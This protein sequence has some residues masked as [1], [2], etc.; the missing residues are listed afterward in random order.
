MKGDLYCS[1]GSIIQIRGGIDL[2]KLKRI[3]ITTF[4]CIAMLVASVSVCVASTV[5]EA[6]SVLKSQTTETLAPDNKVGYSAEELKSM[7]RFDQS[8]LEKQSRAYEAHEKLIHSFGPVGM[9]KASDYPEYYGGNYINDEG[10]LVVYVTGNIADYKQDFL[11]RS[12]TYE[13]ILEP[14]KYSFKTLTQIMDVLNTY[15]LEKP[16]VL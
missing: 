10:N 16:T 14:C 9:L 5:N 15:K 12:G 2:M 4:L 6:G 11:Q 1:L 7:K 3:I 13:I 8:F